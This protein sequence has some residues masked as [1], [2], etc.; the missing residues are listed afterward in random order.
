MGHSNPSRLGPVDHKLEASMVYIG[1]SRPGSHG[2]IKTP[3]KWKC[4]Y[5]LHMSQ[6]LLTGFIVRQAGLKFN[7]S[8]DCSFGA[9]GVN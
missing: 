1:T 2:E 5:C 6:F 3:E 7:D 9:T 8:L 4:S